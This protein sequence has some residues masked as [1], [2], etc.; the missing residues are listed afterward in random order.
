MASGN[1]DFNYLDIVAERSKNVLLVRDNVGKAKPS[2]YDIP[3][4]IT[5]GVAPVADQEG[6]KE[7]VNVWKPHQPSIQD[8]DNRVNYLK[9]N[10]F[11]AAQK[12]VR[13]PSV[14]K[15]KKL[16]GEAD[17]EDEKA[18]TFSDLDLAK[19]DLDRRAQKIMKWKLDQRKITVM[20]QTDK[21][22]LYHTYAKKDKTSYTKAE[23]IASKASAAAYRSKSVPQDGSITHGK[24]KTERPPTPMEMVLG[25]EFAKIGARESRQKFDEYQQAKRDA[26]SVKHSGPTKASLGHATG[27]LNAR[28][29]AV[30]K[31]SRSEWVLSRF[32][33]IKP[34][35]NMQEYL[36]AAPR[37]TADKSKDYI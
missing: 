33:N 34:T 26:A 19:D 25:M 35:M 23:I 8:N 3:Q 24:R 21:E 4:E 1:P 22:K 20:P 28:R 36:R 29:A 32:K 9:W 16:I 13:H 17:E 2:I 10:R 27:A 7:I 12:A 11:T 37:P 18:N 5:F 6:A 30:E 31:D 15:L 14:P